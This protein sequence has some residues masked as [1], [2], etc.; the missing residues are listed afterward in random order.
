[1]TDV[2]VATILGASL[3]PLSMI[4]AMMGAALSPLKGGGLALVIVASLGVIAA[5]IYQERKVR[6]GGAGAHAFVA[7]HPLGPWNSTGVNVNDNVTADAGD[8]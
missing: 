5:F 6:Q 1:M 4:V 3:V 8:A 7:D 2:Q